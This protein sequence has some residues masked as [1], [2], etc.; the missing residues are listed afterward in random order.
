VVVGSAYVLKGLAT[1]VAGVLLA[2]LGWLLA[3]NDRFLTNALQD[4]VSSRRRLRLRLKDPAAQLRGLRR[5][6]Y[7]FTFFGLTLCLVGLHVL[8]TG[9]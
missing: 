3:H 9:G 4:Q 2:L 5:G 8:V 1:I 7:G 6:C